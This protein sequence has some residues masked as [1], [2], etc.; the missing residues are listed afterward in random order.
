MAD[1]LDWQ[2][3]SNPEA[4]VCSSEEDEQIKSTLSLLKRATGQ[5]KPRQPRSK[6]H[7]TAARTRKKGQHDFFFYI[8]LFWHI[9]DSYYEY[10]AM[11]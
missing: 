9:D 10:D 3:I 11:I 1:D 8:V 2:P 6:Q 7:S 4:L 5:Q